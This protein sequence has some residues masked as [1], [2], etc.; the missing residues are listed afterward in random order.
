MLDGWQGGGIEYAV[1]CG[2]C[3]ETRS[4]SASSLAS[5]PGEQRNRALP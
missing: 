4:C 2:L 5:S 1:D 3:G